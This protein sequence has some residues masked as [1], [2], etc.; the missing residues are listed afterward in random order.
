MLLDEKAIQAVALLN[1]TQIPMF[2]LGTLEWLARSVVMLLHFNLQTS[3]IW[4]PSKW[5]WK[6]R[7]NVS[8]SCVPSAH[9]QSSKGSWDSCT[10]KQ[11]KRAPQQCTV[12]SYWSMYACIIWIACHHKNLGLQLL[13][14]KFIRSGN[15]NF[16]IPK[17]HYPWGWVTVMPFKPDLPP[18]ASLTCVKSWLLEPSQWAKPQNSENGFLTSLPPSLGKNSKSGSGQQIQQPLWITLM[19]SEIF[20]PLWFRELFDHKKWHQLYSHLS[21]SNVPGW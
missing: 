18:S 8:G 17:S 3:I 1:L 12:K 14:E 21:N 2:L 13:W 16:T 6:N 4:V 20:G 15:T 19:S 11:G 5:T 7:V 10:Y 9:F